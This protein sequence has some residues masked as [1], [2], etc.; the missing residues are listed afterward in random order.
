MSGG[1]PTYARRIVVGLSGGRGT[2]M[3]F[4]IAAAVF[5]VLLAIW[6]GR[7]NLFRN[8]LHAKDPGQAGH[9]RGGAALYNDTKDLT[10]RRS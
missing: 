3:W 10:R 7:T 8:F 5:V 9:R 6:V 2:P 1:G 4:Y